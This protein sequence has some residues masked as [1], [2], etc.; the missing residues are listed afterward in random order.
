[1]DLTNDSFKHYLEKSFQLLRQEQPQAY[2]Y[3]TMTLR[4]HHLYLIVDKEKLRVSFKPAKPLISDFPKQKPKTE[5]SGLPQITTGRRT[6]LKLID[7]DYTFLEA[8]YNSELE[9]RGSPDDIIVLSRGLQWYL[10]GAVRCRS[11]PD[12][13]SRFRRSVSSE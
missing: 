4:G 1:M 7:G 10:K 5:K 6:I 11:F 3:M 9:F 8:V 12:L 2:K 13:L